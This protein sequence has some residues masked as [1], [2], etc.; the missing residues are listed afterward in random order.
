MFFKIVVFKNFA[1][2]KE[3]AHVLKS[4]F[5][6]TSGALGCLTWSKFLKSYM[7]K[8]CYLFITVDSKSERILKIAVG[9]ASFIPVD[10]G[11]KFNVHK[12][13]YLRPVSTGYWRPSCSYMFFISNSYFITFF[14]FYF[15]LFVLLNVKSFKI[16]QIFHEVTQIF[17]YNDSGDK[18]KNPSF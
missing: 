18:K 4:V 2:F 11:C 5:N 8:T 14:I 10:T 17:Y 6:K 7:L 3:K 16:L 13:F 15:C 12:T 9:N 1:N